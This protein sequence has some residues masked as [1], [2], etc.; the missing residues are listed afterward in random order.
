MENYLRRS[1]DKDISVKPTL[2]EDVWRTGKNDIQMDKLK[3]H[4]TAN[5]I[6]KLPLYGDVYSLATGT[7]GHKSNEPGSCEVVLQF[8]INC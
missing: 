3:Q 1:K 7:S 6:F 4:K 5:F 8:Y 2:L